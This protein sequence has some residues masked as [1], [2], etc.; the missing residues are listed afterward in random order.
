MT[1]L[2]QPIIGFILIGVI[3]SCAYDSISPNGDIHVIRRPGSEY[4]PNTIGDYWEYSVNRNNTQVFDVN[5]TVIGTQKMADNLDANVWLYKSPFGMDTLY[6]RT[7]D[8]TVKFFQIR[9]H[10]F[11]DLRFPLNIFPIPFNDNQQWSGKLFYTDSYTAL[12]DSVTS[13]AFLINRHYIGQNTEY[14]DRFHFKPNIG[15]THIDKSHYNL[16]PTLEETWQLVGYN[17]K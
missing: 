16:G 15:F 5:V 6:V 17:L 14:I 8:D 12:T 7:Y 9:Y 4:F 10:N 11:D 3:Y 1:K 2:I 13:N